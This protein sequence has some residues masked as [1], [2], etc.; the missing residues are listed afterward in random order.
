MDYD[1]ELREFLA[2]AAKLREFGVSHSA[3]LG[4]SGQT[5]AKTAPRP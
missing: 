2:L 1:L 3:P 4:R 5:V